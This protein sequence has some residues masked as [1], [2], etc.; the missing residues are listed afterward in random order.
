MLQ[1]KLVRFHPVRLEVTITSSQLINMFPIEIQEHPKM[2]DIERVWISGDK[3]FS[4]NTLEQFSVNLSAGRKHIKVSDD[5]MLSILHDLEK[6]EIA[7]YYE[8][9][10]DK[11]VVERIKL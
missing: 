1:F 8:G 6:F 7:L 5:K 10:V 9:K 11:Y 2:G 3:V 4:V